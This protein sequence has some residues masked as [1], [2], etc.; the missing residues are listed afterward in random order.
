MAPLIA[1]AVALG[2]VAAALYQFAVDGL[3]GMPAGLPVAIL[4]LLLGLLAPQVTLAAQ[5]SRRWLPVGAALLGVALIVAATFGPLGEAPT[6][7]ASLALAEGWGARAAWRSQ[8]LRWVTRRIAMH[9]SVSSVGALEQ[10][11]ASY[12]CSSAWRSTPM[13]AMS[14]GW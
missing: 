9:P 1:S 7:T 12:S 5:V 3:G 2:F 6:A 4:V 8:W 13:H 10:I 14:Q 11:E